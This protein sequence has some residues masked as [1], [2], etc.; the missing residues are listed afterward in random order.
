MKWHGWQTCRDYMSHIK[1]A[2][3]LYN[4]GVGPAVYG[5]KVEPGFV[6]GSESGHEWVKLERVFT[7]EQGVPYGEEEAG[8]N[9]FVL[10]AAETRE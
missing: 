3:A 9:S 1:A 4:N 6:Q 10:H 5:L 7:S 8:R 2:I